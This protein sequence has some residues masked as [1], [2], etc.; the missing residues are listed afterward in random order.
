MRGRPS[1]TA[2]RTRLRTPEDVFNAREVRREGD[3]VVPAG[4]KAQRT[5]ASILE[6]AS[7]TFAVKGYRGTTMA[8]IADAA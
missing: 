7:R 1:P 3:R 6:A 5:R 2:Q 8:D 4:P